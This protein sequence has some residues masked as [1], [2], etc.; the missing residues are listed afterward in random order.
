ME[1]NKARAR[2]INRRIAPHIGFLVGNDSDLSD[3]L[4]YE[5]KAPPEATYET[6]SAAYAQTV[7]QVA[8]DYPN[9]SLIGTRWR[10]RP[11]PTW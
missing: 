4:G 5:T 11:T 2:E 10:G 3:A 8:H 7:R 6:W 9:L 1:P